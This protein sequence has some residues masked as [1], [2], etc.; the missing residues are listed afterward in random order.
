MIHKWGRAEKQLEFPDKILSMVKLISGVQPLEPLAS[1][2]S[3]EEGRDGDSLIIWDLME[4][5][6]V[7]DWKQPSQNIVAGEEGN[8]DLR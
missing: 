5:D 3:H 2:S 7:V 8:L 6:V 4:E 1:N